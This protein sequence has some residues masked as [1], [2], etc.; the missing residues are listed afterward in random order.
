MNTVDG[1]TT[2]ADLEVAKL[3]RGINSYLKKDGFDETDKVDI[4]KVKARILRLVLEWA[5]HHRD[6]ENVFDRSKELPAWDA[7]FFGK[8]D[9]SECKPILLC[10]TFNSFSPHYMILNSNGFKQK[11]FTLYY[12]LGSLLEFTLGAYLLDVKDLVQM[13]SK[14]AADRIKGKSTEEMRTMFNTNRMTDEL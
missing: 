12:A 3:L 1:E 5:E 8:L 11:C 7:D 10:S 2:E 13:S 4:P 9:D 6:D 14:A